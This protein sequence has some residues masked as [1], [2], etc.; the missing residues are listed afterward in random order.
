M[1][2]PFW[3]LHSMAYVE[4]RWFTLSFCISS[5][6]SMP[7]TE[8]LEP[9]SPRPR[10]S[11]P[12]AWSLTQASNQRA[13][14][15]RPAPSAVQPQTCSPAATTECRK[16]ANMWSSLGDCRAYRSPV[17]CTRHWHSL[18]WSARSFDT[19]CI[20]FHCIYST[21]YWPSILYICPDLC[22]HQSCVEIDIT[23]C[24]CFTSRWDRCRR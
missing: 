18:V 15:P 6:R 21:S 11:L 16:P 3:W 23:A 19:M 17:I 22:C 8:A 10:R 1:K 12:G 13:G 7:C 24:F 5:C 9:A 4:L 14:R 20:H 2:N